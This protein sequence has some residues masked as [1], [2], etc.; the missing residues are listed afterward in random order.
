MS[1]PNR[2]NIVL[3]RDREFTALNADVAH[4]VAEV[5][6][7]VSDDDPGRV[8]VIGGGE[9]Y[10]LFLSICSFAYV[11]KINAFPMSDTFFPNLDEMPEWSHKSKSEIRESENRESGN[12]K[13]DTE[14]QKSETGVEYSF[15]LYRNNCMQQL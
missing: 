6:A 2:R 13:S 7:L 5:L 1:L 15:M 4:S 8:F 10:S 9:I 11:T 12:R 14:N 3:T